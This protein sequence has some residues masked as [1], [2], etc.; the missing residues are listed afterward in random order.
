[1]L[2]TSWQHAGMVAGSNPAHAKIFISFSYFL[3]LSFYYNMRFIQFNVYFNYHFQIIT[4]SYIIHI[5]RYSQFC[6]CK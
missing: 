4:L 5:T 1:M 2:V 3:E 6:K